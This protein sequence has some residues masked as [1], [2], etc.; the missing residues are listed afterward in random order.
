M[1]FV[2][3]G[4]KNSYN[5]L[6]LLRSN[7][8]IFLYFSQVILIRAYIEE[9]YG[10]NLSTS[11]VADLEKQLLLEARVGA[12]FSHFFWAV[13]SWFLAIDNQ[14]DFGYVVNILL[15]CFAL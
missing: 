6:R 13:W 10:T 2:S 3:L 15:H 1:F 12:Q 4:P 11:E 14:I 8:I 7:I 5:F 9:A